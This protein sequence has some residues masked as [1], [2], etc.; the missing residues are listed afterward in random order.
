M[1]DAS[2]GVNVNIQDSIASLYDLNNRHSIIGRALVIHQGE[3]DLTSQPTGAAGGRLACCVIEGGM[4]GKI[5]SFMV[6]GFVLA[7]LMISI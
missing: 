2:G 5:L 7:G 4:F 1:A 6:S 3:D